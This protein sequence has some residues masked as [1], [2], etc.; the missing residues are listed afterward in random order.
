MEQMIVK[1]VRMKIQFIQSPKKKVYIIKVMRR[2][3]KRISLV[4]HL[5]LLVGHQQ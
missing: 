2:S 5:I 4:L 3:L 1:Q